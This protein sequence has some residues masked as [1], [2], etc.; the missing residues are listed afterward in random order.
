MDGFFVAKFKVDKRGKEYQTNG[1]AT[2]EEPL[3]MMINESGNIVAEDA[4]KPAFDE[5]ADKA[6]IE[7]ESFFPSFTGISE[8]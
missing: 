4:G 5:S 6:Y 7:G 2:V 3:Q 8:S 1:A